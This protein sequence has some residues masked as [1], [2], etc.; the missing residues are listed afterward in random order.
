MNRMNYTKIIA[1]ALSVVFLAG[2]CS[3]QTEPRS[4]QEQKVAAQNIATGVA[5]QSI[6]LNLEGE[7]ATYNTLDATGARAV[8]FEVTGA[9]PKLK[10]TEE[11]IGSVAVI[12]NE[13]R[14]T[15]YYVN[16]EWSKEK[17]KNRLY[18]KDFEIKTDLDGKTLNLDPKQTWYIMGYVGGTYKKDTKTVAYNPNGTGLQAGANGE[19]IKK[20][21]PVY[22][23]W[24]K[25]QIKTFGNY[26]LALSGT[27]KIPFK[28]LGTM[29]RV[30]LSNSFGQTVRVKSVRLLTN[31][32]RTTS[33]YY[34][35]NEASLPQFSDTK[36]L[37]TY[38]FDKAI[39]TASA[40]YYSSQDEPI[41][42]L[43]TNAG[44]ATNIDLAAG[45]TSDSYLIWAMPLAKPTRPI[46]HLVANVARLKNGVEQN[47]PK[48]ETLYVWGTNR[49]FVER[50]RQLL[51]A[52]VLRPK[53]P[54]EFFAPDYVG[55]G[56]MANVATEEPAFGYTDIAPYNH[57]I[58]LFSYAQAQRSTL[59]RGGWRVPRY[60][61]A[62][63]LYM[64]DLSDIDNGSHSALAFKGSTERRTVSQ[65]IRVDGTLET[66]TD[67]YQMGSSIYAL[68]FYNTGNGQKYY[69]AWRYSYS[70]SYTAA[71]GA[72][73][74][75]VY[76]GPGFKGT[77][78]DIIN[79][80]FW[81]LHEK[82]KVSR[83]YKTSY[84]VYDGL[85]DGWVPVIL[86]N[87]WAIHEN[88]PGISTG[89]RVWGLGHEDNLY[90]GHRQNY[91][92][93]RAVTHFAHIIPL[94]SDGTLWKDN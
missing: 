67:I 6:V 51:A 81:R 34:S 93:A 57:N 20:A 19:V 58:P 15:F 54:L 52:T 83:R 88:V 5:A 73:F 44:E 40:N 65:D 23:P 21:V 50:S 35:F 49:V 53:M 62:R 9:G 48:M 3:K 39:S 66:Y 77:I 36:S 24:T 46:T 16:I 70:P 55:H 56:E 91:R 28:V 26:K 86:S 80:N 76:L 25:L 2:A 1:L 14:T 82:D 30:T 79:F 43:Q 68:R 75:S 32:L 45:A 90:M 61:D 41:Y 22:F 84:Y 38:K 74:E 4:E 92:N 7:E 42:T 17:D 72:L 27:D 37:P 63:A 33:G 18:A 10:M 85:D 94:E 69:S 11:K 47:L 31:A 64:V 59:L 78:E 60:K 87:F 71:G 12:A 29:M 8:A 89:Q 13:G